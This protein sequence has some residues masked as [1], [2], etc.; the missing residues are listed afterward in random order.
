[1]FVTFILARLENNKSIKLPIHE[2]NLAVPQTNQANVFSSQLLKKMRGF[3]ELH[4]ILLDL[5]SAYSLKSKDGGL[6][7]AAKNHNKKPGMTFEKRIIKCK[8]FIH[9]RHITK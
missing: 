3:Q 7:H 2:V 9:S 1:M 8:S 4:T 5:P 6:Q